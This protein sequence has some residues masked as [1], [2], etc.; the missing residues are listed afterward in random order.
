M[1]PRKIRSFTDTLSSAVA[2]YRS[3]LLAKN[4][5]QYRNEVRARNLP[6]SASYRGDDAI[7]S[8]EIHGNPGESTCYGVSLH[9]GVAEDDGDPAQ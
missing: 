3:G 9:L 4:L 5:R 7:F 2:V 8:V 6:D 1:R